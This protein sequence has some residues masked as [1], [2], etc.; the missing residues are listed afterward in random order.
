MLSNEPSPLGQTIHCTNLLTIMNDK[1]S[2]TF[3]K[4]PTAGR[5][6]AVV[7]AMVSCLV[8]FSPFAASAERQALEC[9]GGGL[10]TAGPKAVVGEGSSYSLPWAKHY[11]QQSCVGNA[12]WTSLSL[13]VDLWVK[14][15]EIC[16]PGCRRQT[17]RAEAPILTGC[18]DEST[19]ATQAKNGEFYA[20]SGGLVRALFEFRCI[21]D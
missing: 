14:A 11:A 6:F 8:I 1:I 19:S 17:I 18:D 3:K 15:E 7:V 13:L 5:N 16:G 12:H 21:P 2:H 20:V 4:T 9:S 10:L